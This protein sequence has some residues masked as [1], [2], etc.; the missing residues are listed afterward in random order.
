MSRRGT[1]QIFQDAGQNDDVQNNNTRALQRIERTET[2][3]EQASSIN[4]HRSINDLIDLECLRDVC[5]DTSSVAKKSR[6]CMS[7]L[8][9]RGGR[10]RSKDEQHVG[11]RNNHTPDG[12]YS[13]RHKLTLLIS[14]NI[15][16]VNRNTTLPD[17]NDSLIQHFTRQSARIPVRHHTAA[18]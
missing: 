9:S 7:T 10:I 13:Y 4:R 18:Q 5:D 1:E 6:R 17:C 16:T 2:T 15:R 8:S 12:P 14:H 11:N 3:R